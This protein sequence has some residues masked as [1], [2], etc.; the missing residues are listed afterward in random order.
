MEATTIHI[1]NNGAL[2]MVNQSQPTWDTRHMEIK[3]FTIQ[4]WV[5]QDLL[6][7]NHIGSYS[8]YAKV[9]TKVLRRTKFYEHFDYIMGRVQPVY[10]QTSE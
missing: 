1:D 9:V 5:E 4:Q 3:H 10:M 2:N 6:Y 7:L 8:S